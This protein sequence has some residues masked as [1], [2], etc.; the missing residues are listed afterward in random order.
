MLGGIEI[1]V[2]VNFTTVA[3]LSQLANVLIMNVCY[4]GECLIVSCCFPRC[5]RIGKLLPVLCCYIRLTTVPLFMYLSL[6]LVC[7]SMPDIV[8]DE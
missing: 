8:T 4:G 7:V 5:N 1:F 2:S 6:F 3:G